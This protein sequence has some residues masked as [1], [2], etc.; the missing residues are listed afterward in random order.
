MLY[1]NR[2][3][4]DGKIKID[5]AVHFNLYTLFIFFFTDLISELHQEG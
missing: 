5:L 3:R 4:F 2:K 1:S